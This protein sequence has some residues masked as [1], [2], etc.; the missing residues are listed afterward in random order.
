MKGKGTKREVGEKSEGFRVIEKGEKKRRWGLRFRG[1]KR[2]GEEKKR[3]KALEVWRERRKGRKKIYMKKDI[4]KIMI[5]YM[6]E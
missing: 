4:M 3:N 6:R 1:I 2:E 5:T